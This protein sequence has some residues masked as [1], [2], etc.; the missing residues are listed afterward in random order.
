MDYYIATT[1]G[2]NV[3]G[4]GSEANPW[5]T[6]EFAH[7]NSSVGDTIYLI[8]AGTY[9]VTPN[10]STD[11]SGRTWIGLTQLKY[12]PNLDV[13]I[14]LSQHDSS[15]TISFIDMTSNETTFKWIQFD[16]HAST[17]T[18][19]TIFDISSQIAKF[20][21]CRFSN[22]TIGAQFS[23]DD[24]FFQTIDPRL[25][26]ERCYFWNL[27]KTNSDLGCIISLD[28]PIGVPGSYITINRCLFDLNG[29]SDPLDAFIE[30]SAG[31]ISTE[32]DFTITNS[33]IVNNGGINFEPVGA[34]LDDAS[35]IKS[36]TYDYN[37]H[38]AKNGDITL[39][40]V[41]ATNAGIVIEADPYFIAYN[42][43]DYRLNTNSPA[44]GS[45][46]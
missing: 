42:N 23:V 32:I 24:G 9:F 46:G 40:G 12:S 43:N 7:T 33:I 38:Y 15:N 18:R 11:L 3:T 34:R 16:G 13:M 19:V 25:T 4:D 35:E 2:S 36:V 30:R 29:I 39:P 14:D 31:G 26:L 28:D 22:H 17:R 21:D 37:L 8:E 44:W 20:E 10:N 1:S 41:W 27:T 5:Q 45:R 6:M